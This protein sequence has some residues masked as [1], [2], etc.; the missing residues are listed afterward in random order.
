MYNV[1]IKTKKNKYGGVIKTINLQWIPLNPVEMY[2]N[3]GIIVRMF[4]QKLFPINPPVT[5]IMKTCKL[6][7]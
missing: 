7:T 2:E 4:E 6:T 3:L 1:G 5:N